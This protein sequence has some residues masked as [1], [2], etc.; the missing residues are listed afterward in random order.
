MHAHGRT[1]IQVPVRSLDR[2]VSAEN[3][4]RV[5]RIAIRAGSSANH[6]TTPQRPDLH[7]PIVDF[8]ILRPELV[9]PGYIF[10]APYRNLD[11]GPYI[12]DN[13]GNLIWSGVA[14]S[15]PRVAHAPRVCRYRGDD[16]LCFFTGTQHQGFSR[17]HGV[18][19]DKHY[20]TVKTI[21]AYGAGTS[22]DMHEFK[23]TPYS[24]GTSVLMTVYQ[25]H[26]YDLTTNPKFNV[27]GG[28]G[29]IVE[30]V[31][32]EIEI[33]TG[34]L[35][36]EWRSL[37]HVDP[38]E[39]WT[40]PHSTDTS[41]EGTNEWH[42]WDYFHLNSIDKNQDGD[43]LI[44]ARHASA[45]YK[46]SGKDGS[47]IWQLGG[48]K[49]DFE[50][51]NFIFSY[52]HHARWISENNTHTVLSFF[53]NAANGYNHS[54]DYSH[55]V[56]VEIDHVEM[57]ATMASKWGAPD[58]QSGVKSISQGSMQILPNG[59]VHIGWGDK[60]Y[61]SE[62][63]PDGLPVQFGKL[64]YPGS[65]VPSYRSYKCHWTGLPLTKPALW[66]F[67]KF[68]KGK[69]FFYTSWNGATEVRSW[70]FFVGNSSTG[71]WNFVAN[72]KK[73]GFET[74]HVSE[75]YG[76]WA[77]S[78]ALDADGQILEDSIIA[79]TFVPGEELRKYCGDGYCEEAE[80]VTNDLS[81]FTPFETVFEASEAYEQKHLSPE[82]GFDTTQYYH[83]ID[84][85]E[86]GA[87]YQGY[88][89]SNKSEYPPDVPT[90][91]DTD[92][93]YSYAD[94]GYQP[95]TVGP[96][97]VVLVIGMIIGF[98]SATFLSCLQ[99]IGFF[100]RFEPIVDS[101]SKKAFGFKY[102][103]IKDKDDDSYDTETRSSNSEG[104]EL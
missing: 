37:D 66:T 21:E 103:R 12:Y 7:A 70:N 84:D 55:G 6:V 28:M 3:A 47:I 102:Q 89:S 85:G 91:G 61:F 43:Y 78:Q 62:H 93:Y 87:D 68:G 48:S 30:G 10:V 31:F 58:W 67:S 20:R 36:F 42:P 9:S 77:Y 57:T 71:P 18:I 13:E 17:G 60:A 104:I 2:Y 51:T 15:G 59:N 25:P 5:E 33:E 11:P 81:E 63:T 24:D 46:L 29:W 92:N 39:A 56:I 53:D 98:V 69:T 76:E 40:W 83:T 34:R 97:S 90:T 32:Q 95:E 86:P 45:I 8:P 101:V 27:K 73:I 16:H 23:M 1:T 94:A 26:Q 44:S 75:S 19:M 79:K 99:S 14:W 96:N 65:G 38:G 52:Q 50:Q 80:M 4:R 54:A 82:R 49:P 35:L 100:R 64:A 41:G 72:E 74:V 88:I 22:S